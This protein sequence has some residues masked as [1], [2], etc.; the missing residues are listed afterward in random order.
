MAKNAL[1]VTT[2]KTS[3]GERF[4]KLGITVKDWRHKPDGKILVI[5]SRTTS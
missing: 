5:R 2:G 3:T 4:A 1:Q